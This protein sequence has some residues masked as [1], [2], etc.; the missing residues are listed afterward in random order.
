MMF[1]T[2]C[3]DLCTDDAPQGVC[4]AGTAFAKKA[5]RALP[6]HAELEMKCHQ[7]A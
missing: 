3:S 4:G 2:S 7:S 1:I 6:A 5:M